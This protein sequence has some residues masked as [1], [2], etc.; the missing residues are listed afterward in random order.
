VIRDS[1]PPPEGAFLEEAAHAADD[2]GG[3][4]IILLNIADYLRVR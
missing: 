2:F 4:P 3:A 1:A